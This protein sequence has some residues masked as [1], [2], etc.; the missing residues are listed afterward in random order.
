MSPCVCCELICVVPDTICGVRVVELSVSVPANSPVAS[1]C[2]Q[3]KL[4]LKASFVSSATAS[5]QCVAFVINVN[6]VKY[7]DCVFRTF[8]W[9]I[10]NLNL[11]ALSCSSV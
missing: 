8:S 5:Q 7:W 9:Q 10:I 3:V 6:T 2:Q 1:H 4:D 11:Q